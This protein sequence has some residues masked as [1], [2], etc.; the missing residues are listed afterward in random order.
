MQLVHLLLQQVVLQNYFLFLQLFKR[1]L[2]APLTIKVIEPKPQF[3]PSE[4]HP[5]FDLVLYLPH[6][7]LHLMIFLL[8]LFQ[9]LILHSSPQ[10]DLLICLVTFLLVL[11]LLKLNPLPLFFLNL[12][13]LF[14]SFLQ[15][16]EKRV[17]IILALFLVVLVKL[18]M[19]FECLL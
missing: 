18:I 3:F 17:R 6:A 4:L 14:F 13:Q 7:L 1:F 10:L 9:G 19:F 15:A 12:F 8:Q 11:F 2:D 5:P 16:V